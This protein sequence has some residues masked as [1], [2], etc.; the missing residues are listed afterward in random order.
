MAAVATLAPAPSQSRL[1]LSGNE[2]VARAVWESGC[3]VAA[4]YPGTPSTEILEALCTYPDIYTEWAVNEK[5]S[6]EVALGASMMG[7]RSFCAMKHV[8]LNVAADPLMT[9]TL[10][11]TVGGMVIVVA[12]DI[13]MASSQN[14]QDSRFYA[15]FAHLPMFEPADSQE[16]YDMVLA[17]FEFSEKHQIPVFVRMTARTCHVKCVTQVGARA[18]HE[19]SGFVK[20]AE[21]WVM[22]PTHAKRRIPMMFQRDITLRAESERSALNVLEPGSDRRVGFVTSGPAYL[23][24]REAFPDAPVLK[25]GMSHPVPLDKVRALAAQVDRLVVVE[26]VEPVVETDLKSAGIICHGKDLLPKLGELAPQVLKPAIDFLLDEGMAPTARPASAAAVFPRPPTLCASCPHMGIY[27]TLSQ[28]KNIIVAG[29]IGCYTLGAGHPW[30]ALDTTI[31]M[32][33]AVTVAHG[34]DKGRGTVDKDKKI[35]A[36]MGDSTFMHMGMQGLLDATYNNSNITFLL[37]DNGTVGMTGGQNTP[38]NGLDIRGNPAPRIDFRKLVEALGV[39]PERVREV[40]P[41]EMPKL[42]KVIREETKI[43]EV[44][45]ILAYRP[46]VLTDEFKA[47]RAYHVDEDKCTGCGNCIDVG[48]PAIHVTH[49]EKV[50]KPSGKEVE[51]AFVRIDPIA[52]TGCGMC[53][54]PCAPDAIMQVEGPRVVARLHP[55]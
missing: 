33:A 17:G 4:A 31:C 34:M 50:V 15:R 1:L 32:G 6:M 23:H 5:V 11:G 47:A 44:S 48:C 25:L 14:E 35:L 18:H 38:A 10:T 27:Y 53:L 41:Y 12:D 52:C 40:D 42:F 13:G 28:L 22:V 39:K 46:C 24:V 9:L 21:R 3:K 54:Q 8:G 55:V 29:D 19:P 37:L 45:V 36:V 2:A 26:E 30:N 7:A 49:R 51:L 16:S 20:N 43:A